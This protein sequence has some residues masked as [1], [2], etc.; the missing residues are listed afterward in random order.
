MAYVAKHRFAPMSARKAR[1]VV[2]MVRGLPVQEALDVL[3]FQPQRAAHLTRLVLKSAVAN[4]DEAGEDVEDLVVAEA[5][6][7]E[8]PTAKRMWARGRGRADTLMLRT[9]HIIIGVE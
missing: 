7:D 2:D 8:G 9:C 1:L 4:A 5:R 6:V 3:E